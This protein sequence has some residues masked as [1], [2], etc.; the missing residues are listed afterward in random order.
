L[1]WARRGLRGQ[2]DDLGPDVFS[3]SILSHP[4]CTKLARSEFDL[5]TQLSER[6]DAV[7]HLRQ[8]FGRGW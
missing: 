8:V 2:A 7:F 3:L 1:E 6:I 5:G 4:P